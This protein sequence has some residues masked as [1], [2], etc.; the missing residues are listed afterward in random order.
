MMRYTRKMRMAFLLA[1]FVPS[2]GAGFFSATSADTGGFLP[3]VGR[4]FHRQTLDLCPTP[5]T[6]LLPSVVG[7]FTAVYERGKII[8]LSKQPALSVEEIR[9]L[10]RANRA[11]IFG[12]IGQALIGVVSL[13]AAAD[14]G[15]DPVLWYTNCGINL[16]GAALW[17]SASSEARR[18]LRTHTM[19][20]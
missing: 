17:L 14:E 12:C 19:S 8:S 11:S 7:T 15:E 9:H 16:V 5:P 13:I 1:F 20:K 3:I 2:I 18:V 6:I 4:R 10:R